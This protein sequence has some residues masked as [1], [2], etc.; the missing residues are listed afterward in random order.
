MPKLVFDVRSNHDTGVSRYGLCLL[1]VAAA[2]L[3]ERGWEIDVVAHRGQSGRA[4]DAVAGLGARVAVHVDSSD[5]GFVRGS[6]GVRAL[7]AEADLYYTSHYLLDRRCP[8]PFVVTV[9]DL[10]RLRWPRLSYTDATFIARFGMSEFGKIQRELAAISGWHDP[11]FAVH[12][13]FTRYFAALNRYLTARAQRVVTVSQS[14][15]DELQHCLAVP[16]DRIAVVPGGVDTTVFRR[17]PAA[18]I[19][20]IRARLGLS[21]PYLVF[22]GLAHPSKRLGWLVEQLLTAR[23]RMPANTRLVA[24][25]GHAERNAAVRRL[26]VDVGAGDFVVFAGRVSD[27]QLAALYSGAA[28]LVSASISEGYGLPLQ[29]ALSCSCEAIVADIPTARETAG[30]V[31]HRFPP[32][33]GTAFVELARAACAGQL[34]ARSS[35][36]RPPLWQT[37]G[38]KLSRVLDHAWRYSPR[39]DERIKA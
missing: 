39:H 10:T 27:A 35:L 17:R 13:T 9:H 34:E 32:A 25:G 5:D 26:L 16:S 15:A 1:P 23:A 22:V 20:A 14:S 30:A 2:D 3:V 33:S 36:H 31:S 38:E 37:A 29:E 24:V 11:R 4:L 18:E 28:A 12:N 8:A 19:G 6:E 21:G 7:A